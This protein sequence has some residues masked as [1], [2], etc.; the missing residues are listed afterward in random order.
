MKGLQ[1]VTLNTFDTDLSRLVIAE[2]DKD[3]N[4]LSKRMFFVSSQKGETRGLHA[5]KEHSQF[6]ICI[7]GSC[8]LK[9][10]NG[11]EI[12]T[13][14]LDSNNVGVEVKPGIW[15]EQMYLEDN[16][17]LVVLSDYLYDEKDYIRNYNEFKNFVL[18]ATK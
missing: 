18:G 5:H 17:I 3:F 8:S 7:H 13:I 16:T 9:F 1:L 14:L 12:Q 15:G 6:M 11:S 10:D 2:S 4:F